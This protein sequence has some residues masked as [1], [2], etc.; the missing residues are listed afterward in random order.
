MPVNMEMRILVVDDFKTMVQLTESLLKQF[1]F[2]QVEVASDGQQALEKLR[3]K[4]YDLI[5]SDWNMEPMTGLELLK[6][7]RATPKLKHIPV[8][9]I[10]AESKAEN[11]I[12]AK[13]AGVN[14]YIIKPFTA[15]TLKEKLTA[16]LGQF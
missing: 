11:I 10:T 6:S 5:L 8:V 9:L 3:A 7:V 15:N 4:S 2:K 14:N 13:Q 16:V 12:A 1:G